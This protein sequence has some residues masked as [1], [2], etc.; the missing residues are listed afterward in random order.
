MSEL[1]PWPLAGYVP[2]NYACKCIDCGKQFDGDKRAIRC[3]ECAAIASK[4]RA[5]SPSP[6]PG[7][8]EAFNSVL[9]EVMRTEANN[10]RNPGTDYR[11]RKFFVEYGTAALASLQPA[12]GER[13]GETNAAQ[14]VSE[15][16]EAILRKHIKVDATGM[17]PDIASAYV[18]GFEEAAREI[19]A[20]GAGGTAV[21][22]RKRLSDIDGH[23]TYSNVNMEGDWEPLYTHPAPSGQAVDVEAIARVV[24]PAAWMDDLP[25]P[26]RA[27]TIQFHERR[28]ASCETARRILSALSNQPA[29]PGWRDM[30]SAPKDGTEILV[31]DEHSHIIS[32]A[33]W[34]ERHRFFASGGWYDMPYTGDSRK[35]VR[36]THWMPLPAAPLPGGA[37]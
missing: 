12:K 3:L 23:Y 22:W 2:G 27:N 5:P 19:A 15:A 26:T 35:L 18:V 8:V 6:A 21:A 31:W 17:A 7:V 32:Q 34:K 14:G 11:A 30:S 20:I 25:V 13:E 10:T 29:Q 9:T 1:R 36:P 28:Q 4:R 24:D 16:V 37:K 33:V